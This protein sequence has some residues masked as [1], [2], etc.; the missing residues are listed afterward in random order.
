MACSMD[1][2]MTW[3]VKR[4]M[5]VDSHNLVS[6]A[7]RPLTKSVSVKI[8]TLRLMRGY[9]FFL[10]DRNPPPYGCL[11]FFFACWFAQ[12]PATIWIRSWNFCTNPPPP[13]PLLNVRPPPLLNPGSA[14]ESG[15]LELTRGRYI[16]TIGYIL[17]T[18]LLF[19]G[20]KGKQFIVWSRKWKK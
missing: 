3:Y 2:Y 19:G 6:E 13:P 17:T 16:T 10:G 8:A 15:T 18:T 7:Y 20:K 11:Q 5:C 9:R 4:F 12:D 14:P 1:I